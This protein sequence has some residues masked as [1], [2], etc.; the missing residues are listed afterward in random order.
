MKVAIL[1]DNNPES[2]L[3]WEAACQDFNYSYIVIDLLRNDWWQKL[4]D[5]DPSFCVS[6]APGNNM[7]YKRVFDEKL[8]FIENYTPYKIFPGYKET[9][10]YE[11]KANLAYFLRI[12]N[13]PHPLT[14][15][16]HTFD[17]TQKFISETKFPI[18]SKTLI[19][20]ASSGVRILRSETDAFKYLNNA[21]IKGVKRRYGPNKKTGSPKTWLRKTIKSPAYLIKKLREYRDRD[22]DIQKGVVLFQQYVPHEYEWRCAKI[23][24]SYFAYKKLKIGQTASGSKQ[25]AYGEPPLEILDFTRELCD[26]YQ[27]NFMAIDM[28]YE[29]NKIL[30]N[31]LQTIF[32]HKN[33]FICKVNNQTGRYI[34]N[35]GS[36]LFEAGDF[37]INESFNLRLKV[38]TD[39]FNSNPF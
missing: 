24:E 34:Y 4:K 15:I 23:G 37:N 12:N 11:N 26:K 13:I 36:W 33:P 16:G 1:T 14:F 38:A 8:F 17:E 28:F 21:F 20:A 31:E 39:L 32:G 5:F 22:E 7:I 27:F 35:N 9:V 19:G 25:F 3:K 6:K 30:V 2:S 10:I 29:N 18:V